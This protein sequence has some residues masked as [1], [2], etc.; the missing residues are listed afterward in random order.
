MNQ[1]IVENYVRKL[2]MIRFGE[3]TE[4]MARFVKSRPEYEE[5]K[6]IDKERRHWDLY[7][8]MDKFCK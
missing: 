7:D 1:D 4:G 5:A 6:R 8:Y 2:R 3:I